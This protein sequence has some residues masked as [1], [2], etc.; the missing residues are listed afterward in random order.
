MIGM[1][2][3]FVSI[4]MSSDGEAVMGWH[5][6]HI[7]DWPVSLLGDV[8]HEQIW[9]SEILWYDENSFFAAFSGTLGF[10]RLNVGAFALFVG[11]GILQAIFLG[12]LV[13]GFRLLWSEFGMKKRS[14]SP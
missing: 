5:L 2:L 7:I 4:E 12:A 14:E 10:D 13:A 9:R 6:F 3:L 8:V 1:V 11:V